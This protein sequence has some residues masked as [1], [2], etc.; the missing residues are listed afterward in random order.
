MYWEHEGGRAIRLGDWK[1]VS[2]K[3]ANWQL[4]NM[5]TDLSETKNVAVEYPEKVKELKDLWNTW[6]RRVGL[7]VPAEIEDTPQEL[8]FYYPFDNNLTDKSTNSYVLQSPNGQNFV[9]GKYHQ[10][11][12]LNGSNQYLDLNTTGIINPATTQ[13]S[14]CAWVYNTATTIPATGNLFEQIILAQKDGPSDA[15]G[16]IALY[17]RFDG[18]KSY[19]NNF[20]GANPNLSNEGKFKRNQWMHVAVV[21]NPATREVSY[22]IDGAKDT[23]CYVKAAFESCNGGFR[24]GGHKAYK[25]YWTGIIDELYV[26]KGLLS[27]AD[28]VKIKD[29]SFFTTALNKNYEKSFSLYYDSTNKLIRIN[30]ENQINKVQLFSVNGQEVTCKKS[31]NII[32]TNNLAKGTYIIKIEEVDGMI[33]SR[34]III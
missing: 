30:S 23:T 12:E 28:I 3:N 1:L 18:S 26:F 27:Q 21:C 17:T 8:A 29:D 7:S 31:T 22:Y 5:I 16:R 25:D 4:F 33:K 14:V 6:A 2:L 13:F 34:N 20:L 10:A 19:Y 9:E 24:I 11:L 32:Y 15:A